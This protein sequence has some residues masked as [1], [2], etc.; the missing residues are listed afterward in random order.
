MRNF[1]SEGP[2]RTLRVALLLVSLFTLA[3]AMMSCGGKSSTTTTNNNPLGVSKV[4]VTPT[5]ITVPVNGTQA[6]FAQALD[7]SNNPIAAGTF[8]WTSSAPGVAV[9]TQDGIATAITAGTAQITATVAT[10][11]S[12]NSTMTVVAPVATV[13]IAPP[14]STV[15]IGG[16]Q[17]FTA[18]AKDAAGNTLAGV[19]ITWRVSFA[20]V[21]TIDSHGLLTGVAPGTVTVVAQAGGQQS[22]PATVTVTP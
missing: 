9:V 3:A 5:T 18:A 1:V 14:T 22:A 16:T 21:A 12:A 15:R 10:I 8:T 20:G 2:G 17:Q 6:F 4:T 13:T 19:V 11:T 7:G